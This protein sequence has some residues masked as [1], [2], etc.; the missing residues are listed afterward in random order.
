MH[1]PLPLWW[2]GPDQAWST[3]GG[4]GDCV[5]IG[6]LTVPHSHRDWPVFYR[7]SAGSAAFQAMV[8]GSPNVILAHRSDTGPEAV[9]VQVRCGIEFELN[10]PLS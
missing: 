5:P 9:L 4:L 3:P 8:D 7:L 6:G 1:H 2:T 10:G